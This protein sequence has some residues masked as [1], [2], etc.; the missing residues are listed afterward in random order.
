MSNSKAD[1]AIDELD[2]SDIFSLFK[3]WFYNVL[4]LFFK[5]VDFIIKFW[6][7][8]LLLIISGVV[9]GIKTNTPTLNK[10]TI[11]VKTNFDSQAYVYNTIEQVT[12]KISDGDSAFISEYD[13]GGNGNALINANITPIIDVVSLLVGISESDSRGSTLT[14]ILKELSVEVDGE[15]FAS[16][17]FFSNYKYHK[18]EVGMIG[19]DKNIVN[20]L[21]NYIN[22]QPEIASIKAGYRANQ[23]E[24][25]AA[26]DQ[27]LEQMNILISDYS[28]SLRAV[29][30]NTDE[31][32]FYSNQTDIDFNGV[33]EL[34]N[35][36]IVE[37]EALKND[38]ITAN[39][40]IIAIGDIQIVED[41]RITDKKYIYYPILF[42]FLF[43]LIA[44]M[45]Y[46]FSALKQ[47]LVDENYL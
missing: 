24:R 20:N 8:A 34:K 37:A 40:A 45:I 32:S 11:I 5:A 15:L 42:L 39:E 47:R 26:N 6:W 19:R 27:T 14:P 46:G 29:S 38:F 21:F 31:L 43:L 18:L 22:N 12:T 28:E 3:R 13:L 9:L 16:D 23:K 25:I 2:L 1:N 36:L 17:R 44:G 4:A 7:V 10:A 41:R 33:F 30:Q 35:E